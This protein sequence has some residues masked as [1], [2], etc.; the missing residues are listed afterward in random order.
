MVAW[1]STIAVALGV[2]IGVPLGIITGRA[3]WD[4][5][6]HAIHVV[7]EPTVPALAITLVAIGA[8]VLANVV[9]ALPGLQ[10]ARTRTAVL[11]RAE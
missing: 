10:A 6:A 8:L 7:D 1:Q 9:A 3:L 11:L 5:F 2:V 4:L